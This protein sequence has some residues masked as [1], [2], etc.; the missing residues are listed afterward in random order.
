MAKNV[1]QSSPEV[2]RIIAGTTIEGVF[3]ANG[4]TRIDG[5]I[6]G[7]INVKGK[8]VLGPTGIIEG[9]IICQNA[10]ISGT[11]EAKLS[12]A[13]L[14]LLKSTAKLTG[15]ISTNKL[16]I[17]PGAEFSGNCSMGGVMK[18]LKNVERIQDEQPKLKE[19]SA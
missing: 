17:E 13:D 2:N 19:K 12:V 10:D 1:E 15:D 6:L 9:D 4:D 3:T 7:T 5:T 11:V 8:L 14:L 18:D 16:A